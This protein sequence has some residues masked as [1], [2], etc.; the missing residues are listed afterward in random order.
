MEI[1]TLNDQLDE[2]KTELSVEKKK[3]RLLEVSSNA[4]GGHGKERDRGGAR[5]RGASADQ[6]T[7]LE[8][9]ALNA[10]QRAELASVR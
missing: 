9:K 8:M 2:V 1:R 6:I 7:T 5:E 10:T 3:C 4:A